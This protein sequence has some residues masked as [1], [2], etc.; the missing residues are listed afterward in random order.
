MWRPALLLGAATAIVIY[1]GILRLNVLSSRYGVVTHPA[2]ARVLT[3]AAP[4]I[5][6]ALEPAIYAWPPDPIPYV[7][8]DPV[9]YLRFAREMRS[10]YQAHVRE[11]MFLAIT[12]LFLWLLGGQDV[13]VSFASATMSTLCVLATFL[14][15][16]RTFGNAVG[17]LAALGFAIDYDVVAWAPDGWRDDTFTFFVVLGAYAFVRLRQDPKPAQA[18]LAG[19]AA[20]AACLTR[21]TSITWILPALL[22]V[23]VEER[24]SIRQRLRMSALVA[25]IAAAL[26]APYLINCWRATGDP[27]MSINEHTV[28]YRHGEGIATFKEPMNAVTYVARKLTRK[29]VFQLDT[30]LG[31]LFVYPLHNKWSGFDLW[32]QGLTTWL[33]GFAVVGLLL[34]A[35]HP[36][37]RFLLLVTFSSLVPYA[38]TW[39]VAG[40]GEWRFTMHA[41]PFFL[42][43]C[44]YA[45]VCVARALFRLRQGIRL[46]EGWWRGRPAI[47]ITAAAALTMLGWLGYQALPYFVARES[48][49]YGEGTSIA[50]GSRDAMF[51]MDGWSPWK[52]EGAVTVRMMTGDRGTIRLPLPERRAY[53]LTLRADPVTSDAPD[54]VTLLLNGRLLYRFGLGWDPQRVGSYSVTV[55]PDLVHPGANEL[56]LVADEVV[57]AASAG[58]RLTWLPPSTPVSLRVWQVRL[59]PM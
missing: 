32:V 26:V 57:D 47:A 19:V 5:A 52:R 50:A 35:G 37:G 17:L 15:G 46:P 22:F 56:K 6:H 11:P 10:F 29:P 23:A 24:S 55:P 36:H 54:H 20:A 2:W 34:W 58:A 1:G 43:A 51:Y 31:G 9:N 7:G 59:N 44:A 21:I 18:A 42:L 33:V 12:R 30:L 13:A 40:G 53:S 38:F 49:S 41:Y 4:P 8:G 27:F 28:Y 3:T 45:I 16:R 48:L 39:N 14:L 25:G